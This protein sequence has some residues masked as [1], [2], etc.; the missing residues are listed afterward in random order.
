MTQTQFTVD[1]ITFINNSDKISMMTI[2]AAYTNM[3]EHSA[4]FRSDIAAI[5]ANGGTV[6]VLIDDNGDL[7]D[8]EWTNG[9][10][11]Q[12]K[13]HIPSDAFNG[14]FYTTDG[15][16]YEFS[17]ERLLAH[18]MFHA[19]VKAT[20]ETYGDEEQ[21]AVDR[22]DLIMDQFLGSMS[23]YEAHRGSHSNGTEN[24]SLGPHNNVYSPPSPRSFPEL[25]N[26][27]RSPFDNA[28]H[29]TSPLVIDLSSGHTGIALTEFDPETTTTFFD[30]KG[31]GFATQTAWTGD[32]TGF[33]VH[34]V[35]ENGIID[36]VTEMFGSPTVDGFAKLSMLDSNHDLQIDSRD[37]EWTS[38]QVWLDENGDAVTQA[39]ELHSL[40]SLNIAKI[41]L[42]GVSASTSSI[43]DNPISHTGTVTF[44]G[45]ATAAIADAWF[46]HDAANS[47]YDTEY[48]LD[49]DTLLMPNLRGSGTIADL[50]IAMSLDSDLK[51]LVSDFVGGLTVDTLTDPTSLNSVV[52]DILY[53]WAGV[54]EVDPSSRGYHVNAQHLEFLEALYGQHFYQNAAQSDQPYEQAGAL[55]EVSWNL[56]LASFKTFLELQGGFDLFDGTAIYNP[57][58]GVAEGDKTLDETAVTDL[59]SHAP[60]PGAENDAY[61]VEI[62]TYI[63]NIKGI[64][65][66]SGTEEGWLDD[67]IYDT[68]SGLTWA[69]VVDM[70]RHENPGTT[71]D[72]TSGADSLTATSG[73]DIM[74]GYAGGDTLHGGYGNDV[75]YANLFNDFSGTGD[76]LYG[77]GGDDILWG[78]VSSTLYGGDG[79]DEL[80]AGTSSTT[81]NGGAGGNYLY[82]GTSSDTYV[83]ADGNDV[84]HETGGSSDQIIMPVGITSGD[85]TF[86]RVVGTN[87]AYFNDLL[88]IVDD[89]AGGTIQIND[90]FVGGTTYQVETIVF[91]D[92]S[93][94]DLSTI[95]NA[96]TFL[97][98]GNDSYSP[99]LNVNQTVHG[100]AGRDD[101]TT[102]SGADVLDGGEGNDTLTGGTGNDT[103]IASPGF[104]SISDGGGADVIEII[105][106]ITA[107]DLTFSR[108]IGVYGP[109][110]DLIINIHGLGEI[111]VANQFY[112]SDYAVETLH[113][114][115]DDS[116][117]NIA[118]QIIKTIGTTGNDTLYGL[119]TGVAG[120]WFDG[121]GGADYIVNGIG[122]NTYVIGAGFG[123]TTISSSYHADTNVMQLTGLDPEDIRMWTDSYGY[124]HLQDLN[125]TSHSI[126]VS[127]AVTG[128]GTSETNI[129]GYLQEISFDDDTTWDLTG[130]LTLTGTNDAEYLYGSANGDTINSLGGGDVVYGNGGNDTITGGSGA[131]Y[132]SGGSGNDVLYGGG[133]GDNLNG[134]SGADTFMFLLG[135]ALG[136]SITIGDFNTGQS[137]VINI[138]DVLD[139]DSGTDAIADFVTLTTSGGS[140]LLSVD[141]DGTGGGYTST[142]IATIYGVTGLNLNDLISNG[143]LIVEAA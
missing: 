133:G 49:M 118:D 91:S 117:I 7:S 77:D 136:T 140:T 76:T 11:Y 75:I 29:S 74:Y 124:L 116:T 12:S 66:L 122:D 3:K 71:V 72:G 130:G 5:L 112:S 23:L 67:A 88:I 2:V 132:L 51:G 114:L 52:T 109:D 44:V 27:G 126:S 119:T 131:D 50:T 19:R 34:D 40:A 87:P 90:H 15:D 95:T 43:N 96:E 86:A 46:V 48:E 99:G 97:T 82:G 61:W 25:F 138:D 63:D 121:R 127:A 142:Q 102:G 100:G 57:W 8:A 113:F 38:L 125:D 106:G 107:S 22:E 18:E 98:S 14:D 58:T 13:I 62:A 4:A 85:L 6:E 26:D 1:G 60:S 28:F 104:D 56:A 30:I 79:N 123:N 111:K 36:D 93:T 42:A 139:Y 134:G 53:K 41:D 31:T 20:G 137:D 128:N 33:L 70:Y 92:T 115:D 35:N 59:S 108:H 78:A 89:G 64:D 21:A 68:D 84:I 17:F 69:D 143:N 135:T 83:F 80:H 105:A 39:G 55:L 45:G 120:N 16:D 101:I 81:L 47:Y 24:D 65:N 94:L 129:G 9:V 10:G 54:E 32:D 141:P 73:D 37:S 103:Y 110:N